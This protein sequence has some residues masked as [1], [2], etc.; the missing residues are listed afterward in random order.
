MSLFSSKTR[1]ENIT[2]FLYLIVLILNVLSF[3]F[4]RKIRSL[5]QHETY[6][7]VLLV[8]IL[9]IFSS[10]LYLINFFQT[11]NSI[12]FM[13]LLSLA[14]PITYNLLIPGVLIKGFTQLNPGYRKQC[15]CQY[16][17]VITCVSLITYY[18]MIT[19][20][21]PLFNFHKFRR[22]L[23][24]PVPNIMVPFSVL[25][26][27]GATCQIST[28][29]LSLSEIKNFSGKFF[30]CFTRKNRER[31]PQDSLDSLLAS[32]FIYWT[33]LAITFVSISASANLANFGFYAYYVAEEEVPMSVFYV[34][35]LGDCLLFMTQPV[36]LVVFCLTMLDGADD[37]QS[38]RD[39]GQVYQIVSG[40]HVAKSVLPKIV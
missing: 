16:L 30:P 24:L 6:L 11:S 36:A 20:P 21:F 13:P 1:L 9:S 23:N 37:T 7:M 32:Y 4:L 15:W 18:V 5:L 28:V 27:T 26:L 38:H 17:Y 10:S 29:I 34:R 8:A 22:P 31:Y 40:R 3:T 39:G 2:W 12:K 14:M 35:V 25:Q 19:S 33:I